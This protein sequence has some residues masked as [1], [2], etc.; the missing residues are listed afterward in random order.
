[1][2]SPGVC[3]EG[4]GGIE[5]DLTLIHFSRTL[6]LKRSYADKGYEYAFKI[7]QFKK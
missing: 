1:M 2:H 5:D 7:M 3:F 4:G 6:L